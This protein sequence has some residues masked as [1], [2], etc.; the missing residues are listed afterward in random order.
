MRGL[1][2]LMTSDECRAL[3]GRLDVNGGGNGERYVCG[4]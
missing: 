3:A 1:V 2:L 4:I